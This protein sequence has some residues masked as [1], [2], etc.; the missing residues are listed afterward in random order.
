MGAILIVLNWFGAHA[1]KL[2]A[3]GVG[4]SLAVPPLAA[5]ARP[6]LTV[7]IIV[8]LVIA[9]MRLDWR[10]MYAYGRRLP[11]VL[12]VSGWMLVASP[13]LTYALLAATPLPRPLMIGIV[14]MAA[15]APIVAAAALALL[16][17]LD[18]TLAVVI[19]MACMWLTPVV[20]PP[21][22]LVLLGLEIDI[23]LYDFM[24]RLG[25][26]IVIAFALGWLGRRYVG[27]ARISRMG[28]SLDGLSVLF[29]LLFAMAIMDGVSVSIVA[30][31]SHV[32]LAL[33]MAFLFNT[34]LQIAAAATFWRVGRRAAVSIGLMSGNR[35]MGLMLVVLDGRAHFDTVIFFAM[36]Q[37][38]M[39]VLPALL[40]PVY[41]RLARPTDRTGV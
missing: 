26:F 22:V 19:T 9:L 18:A 1:T 2:L 4:V 21:V 41:R 40:L 13:I 15:A 30:R 33:V 36:A 5:F 20:L 8:P 10:E 23:S 28:R 35:N 14:L 17:K 25:A 37:I 34:G 27:A 39:Y 6:G 11:L 32:A 12:L 7:F 38:P 29:L 24:A 31:P 16:L 3:L